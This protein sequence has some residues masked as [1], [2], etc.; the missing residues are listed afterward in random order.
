MSNGPPGTSENALYS[1]DRNDQT[2]DREWQSSFDQHPQPIHDRTQSPSATRDDWLN[3]NPTI[4]SPNLPDD[5]GSDGSESDTPGRSP[6]ARRQSMIQRSVLSNRVMRTVVTSSNDALGLLFHAVEQQN[7]SSGDDLQPLATDARRGH[8]DGSY[9]SRQLDQHISPY[10]VNSTSVV[11]G[12]IPILQE[13]LSSASPDVLK[14]WNKCRFVKQGWFTA[15]E[16][17]TYIDM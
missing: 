14:L 5:S 13:Q 2:G 7:G 12:P 17:I 10:S 16:A 1:N 6:R 3:T 9:S 8:H 4:T 11:S 15:R